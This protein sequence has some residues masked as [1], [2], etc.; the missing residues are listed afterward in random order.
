L[1]RYIS[2]AIAAL[3]K[4]SLDTKEL[5]F[6]AEMLLKVKKGKENEKNTG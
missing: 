1:G 6:L 5:K 4:I 3:D 2:L